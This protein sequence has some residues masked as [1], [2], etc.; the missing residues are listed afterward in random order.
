MREQWY[1]MKNYTQY[2]YALI[3]ECILSYQAEQPS[4][5]RCKTEPENFKLIS[6][7]AIVRRINKF[8]TYM[9]HA[10]CC[11]YSQ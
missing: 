2:L 10:K 4:K 3:N 7:S 8:K 11:C 6:V 1:H 9:I 5:S